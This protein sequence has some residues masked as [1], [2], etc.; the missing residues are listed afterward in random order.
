MRNGV[1]IFDADTHIR[2]AAEAIE[3]FLDTWVRDELGDL[4]QYKV[5]IKIGQAGEVREPPYKHYFRFGQGEGWGGGK[6][7][8]LGEA[9][10]RPDAK[11]HFQQFMGSRFPTEGG[12]EDP[13]VRLRDLDEEGVDVDLMVP[14]GANEHP[15]P[16][17]ELAF[18][19]ANHRFLD[20]FCS[21]DPARLKS[22]IVTTPRSIEGSVQ[23]IKTWGKKRW[24]RGVQVFLPLDYP[25]DH[26]DLDPIWKAASDVGL[27]IVHHSFA[28]GY[29]GYRDLWDNPFLGR[30][31]SHPWG[32]M[33]AV[34]AF[35]AGGV[36]DRFPDIKFA[37]LESG[38]GWLPFW[39][40]RMDDQVDYMGYVAEGLKHKPS[41]YLTSGRFACSI[42]QHEG[43]DMVRMV[44]EL[45]GD[46][47]LMFGSDY[48]HAESRFP[49][50]VNDVVGWEGIPPS[51]M[52]K[53]LWDNAVRF[54]G[55]P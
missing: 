32:A 19:Q 20:D 52:Q 46:H 2:C 16:K 34:A 45:M 3:P 38:F 14:T 9:G 18:I 21:A 10:P 1:K 29:P 5:P 39:A 11:R 50:S 35:T 6:P 47:I 22:M 42:V 55:E 13:H 36:M 8:F 12:N 28:S 26:P 24:A 53:L 27:P 44:N 31:A 43:P 54:F 37:V 30:S 51:S 40:K 41:E 48:P 7:R 23:E 25:L 15:N 49:D 4:D 17:I 33:R